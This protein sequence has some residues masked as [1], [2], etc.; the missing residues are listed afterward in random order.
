VFVEI[1]CIM[2]LGLNALLG[3]FLFNRWLKD[4]EAKKVIGKMTEKY[5]GS[6]EYPVC[7]HLNA[8]EEMEYFGDIRCAICGGELN[9]DN[10][11]KVCGFSE[12][13]NSHNE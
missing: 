7:E 9:A 4:R 2:S 5:P 3:A 1:V 8:D 13:D 12:H 6:P 10:D 11:C